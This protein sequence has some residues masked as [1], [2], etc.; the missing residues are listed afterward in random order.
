MEK[1]CRVELEEKGCEREFDINKIQI[2]ETSRGHIDM[3]PR[4]NTGKHQELFRQLTK[5]D[6]SN[7][8]SVYLA[9]YELHILQ[10][11]TDKK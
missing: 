8:I 10:T 4:A 2:Q 9:M 6:I 1:K 11:C 5:Y 7:N 3:N